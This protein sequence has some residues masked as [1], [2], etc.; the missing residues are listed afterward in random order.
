MKTAAD[1]E[2][3][4]E[5]YLSEMERCENAG[6]YWALLHLVVL[7][8]DIC[9][10]LQHPMGRAAKSAY[11]SWCASN[12]ADD[13]KLEPLDRYEMRNALLHHGSTLP[14]SSS[15]RSS[16]HTILDSFSFIEP[17]AAG[18]DLLLHSSPADK[19]ITVDIQQLAMETREALAQ[20]FRGL[21]SDT[22]RNKIVEKNLPRLA[23]RQQK[24]SLV[25]LESTDG[26]EVASAGSSIVVVPV[27]HETLSST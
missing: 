10:A 21:Q 1:L 19:N 8:P 5:L 20:W 17:G 14:T 18:V 15:G 11:E 7:M 9:A 23:R 24:E 27:R 6:A 22:A 13:A 12:F 2:R 3:A 4:F 16:P 25:P 26:S